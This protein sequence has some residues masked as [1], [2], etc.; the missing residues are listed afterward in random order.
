[1]YDPAVHAVVN[2]IRL[3]EPLD[4]AAL[5]VA[6]RD[7]ESQ[8]SQVDGLAAIHVLRTDEGDL[9]VLVLGDDVAALERTREHMG[10]AFMRE[11]IMPH[12]ASAPE[13]TISEIVLSYERA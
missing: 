5:A 7:L 2:R 10:N 8:A 9:V 11:H 4:D 12:A 1:M 6:Q 13:R 3:R